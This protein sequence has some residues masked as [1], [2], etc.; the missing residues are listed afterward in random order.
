MRLEKIT[1]DNV[2]AA[3]DLRV[4]PEQESFV[5]PVVKSLAEAY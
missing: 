4:A 2:E 5:A 3:G 1:P